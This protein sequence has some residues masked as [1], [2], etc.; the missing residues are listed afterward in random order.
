MSEPR[1]AVRNAASA[2]QTKKASRE[3]R[4]ALARNGADLR[5][6]MSSPE[7]RRFIWNRVLGAT[8]LFE[9]TMRSGIDYAPYRAGQ[10]DFGHELLKFIEDENPEGL[11]LMQ[12]EAIEGRKKTEQGDEP[13]AG[14]VADTH[15]EDVLAENPEE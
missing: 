12:R 4:I 9:S 8:G 10:Q 15:T 5:V 6:V 13:E 1:A 14:I 7:G 2:K 3:E 11:L